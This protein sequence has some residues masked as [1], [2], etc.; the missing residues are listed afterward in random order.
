MRTPT[1]Q[2]DCIYANG[3]SWTFGSELR[4]P[5]YPNLI[6]NWEPVHDHYRQQYSW[7][8]LLATGFNV[9]IYNGSTAGGGNDRILRTTIRDVNKL[10]QEGLRPFVVVAWS[11]LHRFEL[12]EKG[13]N[14]RPF[15][16][17]SEDNLPTVAKEIFSLWSSDYT[18]VERWIDQ[19]ITFDAFLK[20]LGL[21]YLATTVFSN[22][23]RLFEQATIDQYFAPNVNY[24]KNQKIL[25]NN[26]LHHSLESYLK[27]QEGVG[28]GPGGHPLERGQELIKDYFRQQMLILFQFQR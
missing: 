13:R 25:K 15:V 21:D 3:C 19:L 12:P 10:V 11:Q 2:F 5:A 7:P 6:S 20:N 23:Y 24:L 1:K 8:T 4:N 17:P 22:S 9:P 26:L 14:W 28:Y 18:D 16:G 27:Q